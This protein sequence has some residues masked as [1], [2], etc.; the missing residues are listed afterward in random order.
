MVL[1]GADGPGVEP[2][3]LVRPRG[4]VHVVPQEPSVVGSYNDVVAAG[5]DIKGRDV[6]GPGLKNLD[7]LLALE[8][9]APDSL[10]RRDEEERLRRV[11]VRRLRKTTKPPEGDLG[12]VL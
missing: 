7:K 2:H 1:D 4:E 9:V 3:G 11:E 10:S 6:P 8:I 12:E 5:V